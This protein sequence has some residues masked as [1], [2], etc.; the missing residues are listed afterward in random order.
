MQ[1]ILNYY[2]H[3]CISTKNDLNIIHYADDKSIIRN[4]YLNKAEVFIKD[5]FMILGKSISARNK[6]QGR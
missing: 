4:Q 2:V 6:N 1:K 3:F 5:I